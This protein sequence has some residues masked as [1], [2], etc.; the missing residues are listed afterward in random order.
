M[1]GILLWLTLL[2]ALT[3]ALIAGVF[4]G[5]S[6]FIMRA[7]K[8]AGPAAGISAMQEINREV[9]RAV[10]LAMMIGMAAL[11]PAL[12]LFAIWAIG[13]KVAALI[14]A[15]AITYCLGMFGVTLACNVPMNKRLDRM[16]AATPETAAY[17]AR[18][19]LPRWTFWNSVRMTAA[20]LAALLYIVA[21]L[22][23]APG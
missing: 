15:A 22:A 18:D 16:D 8:R 5:F 10:F 6:D 13:G 14:S 7:L 17:W 19:F 2:A 4:L 1:T 11:S 20:A 21:A 9:Y 12:A 23:L 3:A